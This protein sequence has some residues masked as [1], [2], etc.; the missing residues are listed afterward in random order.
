MEWSEGTN[1]ECCVEKI[2]PEC[3]H[4]FTGFPQVC[5]VVTEVVNLVHKAGME[6]VNEEDVNE[7]LTSHE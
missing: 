5:P 3:V 4:N 6:E 2:W 1:D 7:L